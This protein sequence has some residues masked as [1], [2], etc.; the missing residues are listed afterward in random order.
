M[1][2]LGLRTLTFSVLIVLVFSC[3]GDDEKPNFKFIDQDAQGEIAGESWAYTDGFADIIDYGGGDV[4][5]SV[6]LALPQTEQGCDIFFVTGDKVF[7]S[8]PNKVGL[9]KLKLDLTGN[10][11]GNY[12]VTLF[13]NDTFES[14]FAAT[15]AIEIKSLSDT[16]VSGRLDARFDSD[17]YVNGNF[18]VAICP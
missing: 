3:G 6:N 18:T 14:F 17:T 9:Y 2:T 8:L 1:R 12:F 15:G 16:E 11:D 4:Q 5:V 13:N 10:G 7:F